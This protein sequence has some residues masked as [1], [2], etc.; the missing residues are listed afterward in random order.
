MV[1]STTDN[2]FYYFSDC[3]SPADNEMEGENWPKEHLKIISK[4]VSRYFINPHTMMIVN[5]DIVL[6]KLY[7]YNK[8][9]EL[10]T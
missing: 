7:I 2:I 3:F 10:K 4:W 1:D 6:G 9:E 5:E 8:T